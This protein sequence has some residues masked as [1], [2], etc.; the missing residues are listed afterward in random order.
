MTFLLPVLQSN[1]R[2]AGLRAEKS[3]ARC[4]AA[5]WLEEGKIESIRPIVVA[6]A[7]D[8]RFVPSAHSRQSCSG[9]LELSFNDVLDIFDGA[10]RLHAL[11]FLNLSDHDLS[12]THWPVHFISVSKNDDLDK[13]SQMIRLQTLAPTTPHYL[14]KTEPAIA[15]WIHTVVS[16]SALLTQSVASTKSSLAPRSARLWTGSA[17]GKALRFVVDTK[18]L[19]PTPETSA[20]LAE[21]FDK[22][23]EFVPFLRAYQDGRMS[24]FQIRTETVIAQAPVF[25]AIAVTVATAMKKSKVSPGKHFRRLGDIRWNADGY[26]TRNGGQQMRKIEWTQR[27]LAV[28]NLAKSIHADSI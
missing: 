21:L 11:N 19:E 12:N 13:L 18:I 23:P 3:R 16:K 14:A 10:Q 22:L 17:V 6:I 28:C 7:N 20:T 25:H 2:G 8:Y 27:L 15:D 24:A 5:K 9:S 4:I 1:P 26:E